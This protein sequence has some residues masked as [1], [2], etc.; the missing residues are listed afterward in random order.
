MATHG[1]FLG[2]RPNGS[3]IRAIRAAQHLSLRT[4]ASQTD[5]DRGHLSRLERGQAGA[6]EET[7]RRIAQALG[8]P[9]S[10]ITHEETT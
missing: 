10:A 2:V 9:L 5:R 4:L 3:A 7:I 1:Y 6:S 8:V